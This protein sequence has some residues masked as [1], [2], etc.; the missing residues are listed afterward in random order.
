MITVDELIDLAQNV[1][2]GD[3]IDWSVLS[4]DEYA[5]YN[6]IAISVKEQF[7]T[8]W[9]KMSIEMRER[10]MLAVITK[11]VVENFVERL[12]NGSI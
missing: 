11:L 12:R 8:E 4:I 2:T 9:M 10:A 6:L 7:D 3:P 5:A 1:E